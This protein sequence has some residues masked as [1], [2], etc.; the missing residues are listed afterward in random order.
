MDVSSGMVQ[1]YNLLAEKEGFSPA[2]MQAIQGNLLEHSTPSS[3]ELDSAEYNNFDLIVMSMALHHVESAENMI[4]KLAE[5]LGDNGVL[6]IVDWVDPSESGCTMPSMSGDF[7]AQ[8]TITRLGFTEME[9]KGAFEKA[10]LEEWG[11]K[12]FPSRTAVPD[13][14]HGEQQLFVARGEKK[15]KQHSEL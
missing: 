3:S 1:Q 5:R 12:W 9:L 10:G 6:V 15:R 4:Q 8:H 2:R 14:L 13:E 7:P 11:W